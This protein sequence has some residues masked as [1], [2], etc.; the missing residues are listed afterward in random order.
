MMKVRVLLVTHNGEKFLNEQIESILNQVG[1]QVILFCADTG[2]TDQTLEILNTWKEKG[3]IENIVHLGELPAVNA[4]LKAIEIVNNN[5]P[6]ALSD[7]DD[8][9]E[10]DKLSK[11]LALL[12]NDVPQLICHDRSI[13]DLNGL[14]ILDSQTKVRQLGLKNALIENVVFGN[15]VLMNKRGIDLVRKHKSSN[16]VMH[17]SFIYLL[18]SCLGQTTYIHESLT[19]YRIHNRNLV[20]LPNTLVRI[21]KFRLNSAAFYQQNKSFF[22]LYYK[23]IS[24]A[25]LDIFSNYF[26]ILE[27]E[28]PLC[29]LLYI[30]TSSIRRQSIFQTLL[31]KLLIFLYNPKPLSLINFERKSSMYD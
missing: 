15:T 8:I 17:D 18:F 6:L 26:K 10:R 13:I 22:N 11:Q 23:E 7:Q 3:D 25:N 9:W 1:C 24:N 29:R 2:S 31:W 4:F 14:R 19:R 16:L 28:R 5:F 20:G 12:N 30:V 27:T 21:K